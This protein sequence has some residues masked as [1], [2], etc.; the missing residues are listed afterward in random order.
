M[1]LGVTSS[2]RKRQTQTPISVFT[3]N[4]LTGCGKKRHESGE[5]KRIKKLSK[6]M[7]TSC[8]VWWLRADKTAAIMVLFSQKFVVST[9]SVATNVHCTKSILH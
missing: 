9:N 5:G 3:S 1:I 6:L 8:S 4:E 2:Q 7:V